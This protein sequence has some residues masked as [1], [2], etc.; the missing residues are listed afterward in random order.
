M[1]YNVPYYGFIQSFGIDEIFS[2]NPGQFTGT[3]I[4][5]TRGEQRVTVSDIL[6]ATGYLNDFIKVNFDV[7]DKKYSETLLLLKT[8]NL[9]FNNQQVKEPSKERMHYAVD[10][11]HEVV[12]MQATCSE[13]RRANARI[14][15]TLNAMIDIFGPTEET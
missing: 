7:T 11:I 14:A 2:V 4:L 10:V 8:L 12:D 1:S 3:T 15:I 6:K 13:E 9:V 5:A